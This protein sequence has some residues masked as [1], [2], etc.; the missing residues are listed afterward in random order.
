[1]R[2]LAGALLEGL[3]EP[4]PATRAAAASFVALN[5]EFCPVIESDG[6]AVDAGDVAAS[7]E[8]RVEAVVAVVVQRN[9]LGVHAG[10][11]VGVSGDEEVHDEGEQSNGDRESPV[12]FGGFA[13]PLHE[14]RPGAKKALDNAHPR[15][16][17]RVVIGQCLLIRSPF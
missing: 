1:M 2:G 4:V 16:E 3:F 5:V 10:P 9:F 6:T 11:S 13:L 14:E 15:N 12:I 8:L 17:K 7:E